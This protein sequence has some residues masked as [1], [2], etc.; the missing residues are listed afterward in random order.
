MD[1]I[2][3]ANRYKA[4]GN[5]CFAA[6]NYHEAVKH[7]TKAID[8]NSEDHV[9]YSNRSACYA[10]LEEYDKA[11]VD[12]Q[13]CVDIK[14]DWAKGY[15]RRGLAEFYLKKYD[16]AEKTYKKGLDLEP[17]N[18][19]LMEGLER[20][21]ES[22]SKQPPPQES[23][24]GADKE[25]FFEQAL[26]QLKTNPETASFFQDPEFINKINEIKKNPQS[27]ALYMNDPKIQK[28]FE[29]LK[30]GFAK[31]GAGSAGKKTSGEESKENLGAAEEEKTRGNDEY[32]K[33]NFKQALY[34]YDKAIELN[35]R[36]G[37]YHNNK[38]AVYL[39]MKEAEKVIESCNKAIE[40]WKH[41][42]S[43]D[44]AKMCKAYSRKGS[45][46]VLKKEYDEALKCYN[47]ALKEFNDPS[48]L[49]EI[50]KVEALKKNL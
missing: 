48:I 41:S 24:G 22:K 33:K 46:Y 2:Q 16:Q 7:F 43:Y 18:Q 49:E 20:V 21:R 42:G 3:E 5:D 30:A 17:N 1:D 26:A 11:L 4:L 8:L 32:K 38:A 29:V 45:A 40:I 10:C 27:A 6:K 12:A 28:A 37:V 14:P 15:L 35:P 19:Q 47:Q 39:E 50:R 13:I 25:K 44:G 23:A 36:E 9:F 31:G 34:H